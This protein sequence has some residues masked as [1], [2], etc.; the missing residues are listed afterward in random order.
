MNPATDAYG[1]RVRWARG[2]YMRTWKPDS[3]GTIVPQPIGSV[4]APPEGGTYVL[5]QDL[6]EPMACFVDDLEVVPTE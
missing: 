1:T 6:H 5:W 2:S 3:I 4:G